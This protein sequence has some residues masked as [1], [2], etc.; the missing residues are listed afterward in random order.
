M[1]I[2]IK[3]KNENWKNLESVLF[4]VESDK[5]WVK[6]NLSLNKKGNAL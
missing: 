6:K 2:Q 5:S 3:L 4:K 1:I